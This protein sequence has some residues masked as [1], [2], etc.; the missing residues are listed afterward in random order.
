MSGL[1][2]S[3][4]RYSRA[5]NGLAYCAHFR[6]DNA[7]YLAMIF[8]SPAFS[9]P[10]FPCRRA[11][12]LPARLLHRLRGGFG[13]A[14]PVGSTADRPMI[15]GVIVASTL[16]RIRVTDTVFA[17]TQGIIGCMIAR[18]IPVSIVH[19]AACNGPCLCSRHVHHC[20]GRSRG[21]AAD[22]LAGAAGDERDLGFRSGGAA[23]MTVLAEAHGATSASLPSC[24]ICA[25][26]A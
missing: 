24:N 13:G 23:A 5:A 26:C 18:A 10:P 7:K 19:E 6:Q 17:A 21:V 11:M 20:H 12:G 2:K 4:V 9:K 25:C 3:D 14:A 15:A 1:P 16:G 22:T 8:L